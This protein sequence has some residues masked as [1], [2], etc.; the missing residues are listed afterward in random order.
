MSAAS[1]KTAYEEA[2]YQIANPRNQWTA[3]R[4]DGSGVAMTVWSDEIDKTSEPWRL[5]MRAHPRLG[6]WIGKVGNSVRIRHL[7]HAE[8]SL[9]GRV[10]L[11]LCVAEDVEEE[12]RR[13]KR[14]R[15]WTQRQGFLVPGTLNSETGEF[16]M[17]LRPK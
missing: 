14:A 12:P 17:E 8:Q 13:I 4:E 10:D 5:D 2:G 15:P 16:L 3:L 6:V 9:D 7:R 11:I 1:F